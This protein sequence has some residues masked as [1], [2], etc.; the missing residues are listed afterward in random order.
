MSKMCSKR[1]VLTF[2][3]KIGII[4]PDFPGK[5]TVFSSFGP[6]GPFGPV[7]PKNLALL[8]IQKEYFG[9]RAIL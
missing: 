5:M 9:N 4:V 2:W 1:E 7:P 3:S 6:V 8:P